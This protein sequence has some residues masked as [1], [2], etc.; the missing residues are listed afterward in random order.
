MKISGTLNGFVEKA[1]LS[2]SYWVERAKL[3]F[4]LALERQRKAAGLTYKAVAEKLGT[5]AA[6]VTKVFRGDTNMTIETMVKLARATGGEL[7]V[8]I[9]DFQAASI[10]KD[11]ELLLE[12]FASPGTGVV[13]ITTAT[14]VV[15][16]ANNAAFDTKQW[17]E[18]A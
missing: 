12:R 17:A 14:A 9:L 16:A 11:V 10:S 6:Y 13:S 18:A 1:R 5:S 7:D 3:N 2:D 8:R 15:K 4:A